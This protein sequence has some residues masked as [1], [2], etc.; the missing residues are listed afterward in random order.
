MKLEEGQAIGFQLALALERCASRQVPNA[1]PTK[2]DTVAVAITK[3][4]VAFMPSLAIIAP[5][6]VVYGA[7][8]KPFS[9]R[10]YTGLVIEKVDKA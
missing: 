7:V 6:V 9:V 3:E 2:K 10:L 5:T 4:S 1:Q 8:V